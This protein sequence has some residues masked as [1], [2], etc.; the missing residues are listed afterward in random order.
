[1]RLEAVWSKDGKEVC[2]VCPVVNIVSYENIKD[3]ADIEVEN[4]S[5]WHSYKDFVDEADDFVIRI[6]KD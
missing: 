3:V 2:K 1:M 4:G 5:T 6:E